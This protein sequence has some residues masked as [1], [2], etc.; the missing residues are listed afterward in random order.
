[1]NADREMTIRDYARVVV[2]RKWIVI[3]AVV[4]SVVGALIMSL[5]Q[6]PIYEAEAQMLVEPRLGAAVFQQDPTLNVQN[7]ERA[8]QTEIQVLEGQRVR[9]RVREDLGLDALPPTFEPARSAR[10]T[11]CRY[12]CGARTRA[13]PKSWPTPTSRRT[14]RPRREQA[15][16]TLQ[17]AETEL[18]NKVDELQA[19]IDDADPDATCTRS[20]PSRRRSRSGWTSCRSTPPSRRAGRRS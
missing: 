13:P 9:E 19:Q 20:S 2:R 8:I 11:S 5:A 14:P 10:P 12:E 18:S 7:L 17:L 16:D 15:I 3:I 6:D 4:A 1:M